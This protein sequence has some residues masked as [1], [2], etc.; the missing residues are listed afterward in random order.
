MPVATAAASILN[1]NNYADLVNQVSGK[2]MH[3]SGWP[4]CTSLAMS[5]SPNA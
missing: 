4:R 3:T 5:S 2:A 1:W